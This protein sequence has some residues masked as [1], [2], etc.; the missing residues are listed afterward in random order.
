MTVERW[1]RV[2]EIVNA[3]LERQGAARTD[4]LDDA[5]GSDSTLRQEVEEL[6]SS[7]HEAGDFLDDAPIPVKQ[8]ADSAS[9]ARSG[10]NSLCCVKGEEIGPYRVIDVIGQGGMG[11]V[12]RCIRVDGEFSMQVAVKVVKHGM[13]S[14]SA[15]LRRFRQERQILAQLT[16]PNIARLLDGGVTEDGLPYLVMEFVE[17]KPIDVWCRTN[18]PSIHE[19]LLLFRGVASALQYAHRNLIV[20]GDV[21][22]S[23]V[24][25]TADGVPKLLDFGVAKLLDPDARETTITAAGFR[26]M[27]PAYASPEQL[28]GEPVGTLC[29]LYSLG[30]VLYELLA[31]QRPYKFD[32]PNPRAVLRLMESTEVAKPSVVSGRKELAGDLDNIALKAIDREPERRYVSIEQ[33]SEDLR[34]YL[35]GRPVLARPDTMWYRVQKFVHRNPVSVMASLMLLLTLVGGVVTTSWQAAIAR[36]EHARAQ[37]RFEDVRKLANAFLFE[38]DNSLAPLIGSTEVR[39]KLA[40]NS[41]RYLDS[42]ASEAGDDPE[43]QLELASAYEKL[44]DVHGRPNYA[45]LGNTDKALELYR[46]ALAIRERHAS[47][48]PKN[49]P[50]QLDLANTYTAV[51]AVQKVAGDFRAGLEYDRKAQAINMKLVAAEPNNRQ[52]RRALASTFTTLGASL[53]HIGDWA[54]VLEVRA[55]SLQ[56]F[57][58]MVAADPTNVDNRRGLGLAHMRMGSIL[59]HEGD[60]AGA[61]KHLRQAL[62]IHK[63]LL[64]ERPND[65]PVRISYARA[66]STLGASYLDGGD[67][68]TALDHFRHAVAVHAELAAADPH[69]ARMRSLLA[70]SHVRIARCLIRL[71]KGESAEEQLKTALAL[72]QAV[73]LENPKNAGA[74]AEVADAYAAMGEAFGVQRKAAHAVEWFRRAIDVYSELDARKQLNAITQEEMEKTRQELARLSSAAR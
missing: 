24:L 25:V 26:P 61:L 74:R 66:H 69:D 39:R 14:S 49:L 67:P 70:T 9:H 10:Q 6:I 65:A 48:N 50:L 29:D 13:A 60:R 43:L 55:K 42:L 71:G 21:K 59:E 62:E 8:I 5:C 38:L 57:E 4:F 73:S 35:E 53:S 37:R 22:P 7:F 36:T 18:E 17:G 31:G 54:G 30:V 68:S 45:N 2:K 58:E 34:R 64:A 40:E 11:T 15:V 63:T 19:R 23:N 41:L 16:H 46:K 72:R 56:M 47:R 32:D 33:L 44:G 51:G 20:H 28:R 12:Y 27:T 52:Y 3:G 1:Q